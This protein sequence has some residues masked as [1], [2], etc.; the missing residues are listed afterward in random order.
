MAGLPVVSIVIPVYN[1]MNY[2][3]EAI[4]SVLEQDYPHIELIVLDDGSTDDTR[5]IL[6]KYKDKFYWETH[7]NMGQARTLN[8]GWQMAHGDV[9][10]YL[11]AD[12]SL[13]PS[14]VSNSVECL[15]KEEEVILTY[16]DYFL[17]SEQSRVIQ[18]VHAPEVE[19]E[20]MVVKIICPPGPGAFFRREGFEKAGLWNP[21]LRQ[22]PD[23]D[24]WIRL[25]LHG[26]FYKITE[27][28]AKFRIHE[29]SQSHAEPD[30]ERSEEILGVM[31]RYFLLEGIPKT[32]LERKKKALSSAYIVAARFHLRAGRYGLAFFRLLTAIQLNPFCLASREALKYMGNGL[33]YRMKKATSGNW[34]RIARD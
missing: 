33:S 17:V 29:K 24:Y 22:V 9:L 5:R 32:V 14:A 1:G 30:K 27:P 16:C 26:K 21:S 13:L 34:G 19:Y 4:D 28:L 15:L 7:P 10:G 20:D 6:E 3:R 12:D 25:G 11:S 31:K 2:L 23:Y 8:K 18:R